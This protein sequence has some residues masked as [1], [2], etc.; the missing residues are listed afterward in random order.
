VEPEPTAEAIDAGPVVMPE[1][2]CAPDM[3]KVRPGV[4][5]PFCIDR[6]E[7]VL[8]DKDSDERIPPYYSPSRRFATGAARAWETMRFEMGPPDKQAIPL[9]PLP[10]WMLAK[11]FEPRAVSRKGVLPNGHVTGEQAIVACRNA[12]KRLCTPVEWRAACGGEQGWQFP[13]GT[14]YVQDACNVYREGHPAALLHDNAAVG[15]TDPRLNRVKIR[16]KPLL[17]EGGAT[18]A[19]A[20]KWGDDAVYDMVGNVDEWV[21]DPEGTFLGGFY[22]RTAK[23][24]CDKA[25]KGHSI[26]YGDYSTGVRCC[27]D[28][29]LP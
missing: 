25:V 5:V 12:Q 4:G 22:S 18:P 19:C 24:G 11:D 27:A 7:A 1:P 10:A 13:Y 16:G 9:P 15:H 23:E 29:P 28:L 3:V 8:L 26:D 14:E 6:Y 21:D 17:R 2:R 20:S